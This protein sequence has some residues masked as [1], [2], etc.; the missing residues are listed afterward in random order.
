[1]RPAAGVEA[2][3]H[4]APLILPNPASVQHVV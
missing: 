3:A 2:I 4:I 1:V